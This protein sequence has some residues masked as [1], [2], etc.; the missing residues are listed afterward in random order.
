[1]MK[2]VAEILPTHREGLLEISLDFDPLITCDF[3]IMN[4][5]RYAAGKIDCVETL[6]K[7]C[8]AAPLH[9]LGSDREI[10]VCEM[11]RM[12]SPLLHHGYSLSHLADLFTKINA[13]YDMLNV[14]LAIDDLLSKESKQHIISA[15]NTASAIVTHEFDNL[16]TKFKIPRK[17]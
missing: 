15:K 14:L 6:S 7:I 11:T 13:S 17:K 5:R 10:Y 8:L 4:I 9:M 16:L 1:M 12:V 3:F 2:F